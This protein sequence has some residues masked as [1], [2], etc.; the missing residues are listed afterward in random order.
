MRNLIHL[1]HP[2]GFI[3]VGYPGSVL[4]DAEK[5]LAD[6]EI[7]VDPAFMEFK[8]DYRGKASQC[9]F[10][11]VPPFFQRRS[12]SLFREPMS[13]R[14]RR[15]V[16]LQ[17][18]SPFVSKP[19]SSR[20]V[21]FVGLFSALYIVTA[22]IASFVTQVGYP[23]H[24]LRGILMTALVLQTRKKWSATMMGVVCGI[25]FAVLVPA[26]APYLLPS[27]VLSGLIFDLALFGFKSDTQAS[28]SNKR[29]IFA[30]G[31][32]GFA[33]SLVALAILT[34]FAPKILGDTLN[35]IVVAWSVDAVLNIILSVVGA[36]IA[37]AYLVTRIR[38]RRQQNVPSAD[39]S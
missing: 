31:I 19:S 3:F 2:S 22:S 35:A 15:G 34:M 26:P 25:I 36:S 29:L 9:F 21:A 17:A 20:W 5:S 11:F 8:T 28:M 4:S 18:K 13:S 27:T 32:S 24:F 10:P 14:I 6:L 39:V 38:N 37:I 30:A 1:S 16:I 7:K 23:E 33:E 12:F